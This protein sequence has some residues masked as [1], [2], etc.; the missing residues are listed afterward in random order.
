MTFYA[1]RTVSEDSD[2]NEGLPDTEYNKVGN[3]GRSLTN[4]LVET[5][6]CFLCVLLICISILSQL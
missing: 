5:K 4:V 6:Q 2:T 3:V 1:K